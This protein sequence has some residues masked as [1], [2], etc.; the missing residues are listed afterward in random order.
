MNCAYELIPVE[1]AA[2]ADQPG[3]LTVD[4]SCFDDFDFAS[5]GDFS[6][7]PAVGMDMTILGK[8]PSGNGFVV[9]LTIKGTAT[10]F[11]VPAVDNPEMKEIGRIA[12]KKLRREVNEW[13]QT[14]VFA[15]EPTVE[16]LN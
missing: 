6:D 15:D 9:M 13:L 16:P 2:Y 5:L 14:R 10:H 12:F 7:N 4:V 3:G 8:L 1:I 11:F